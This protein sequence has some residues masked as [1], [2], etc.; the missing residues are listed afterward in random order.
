MKKVAV[1]DY[2]KYVDGGWVR[3]YSKSCIQVE[4]G[5][6]TKLYSP[7]AGSGSY[8]DCSIST[9]A[10]TL[11][12]FIETIM[13]NAFPGMAL[14]TFLLKDFCSMNQLITKKQNHIC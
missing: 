3:D 4:N 9:D 8:E 13:N 12:E 7:S 1:V 11:E 14:N 6:G 10:T 5:S 2:Y